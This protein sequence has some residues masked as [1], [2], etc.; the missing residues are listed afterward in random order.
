LDIVYDYYVQLAL[1]YNF[2]ALLAIQANR[3]GSKVNRGI[4]S[5]RLLMMEDV[6]EAWGPMTSA[7]NVITLNR[8]VNAKRKNRL[9]LYVAKSRSSETGQAIVAQSNFSHG[10]THSTKMKSTGYFGTSTMEGVIDNYL[11]QF[12][13]IFIPP[14]LVR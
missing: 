3:E 2:H 5:N 11:V 4:E 10:L 1:E 6:A 8:S 12:N 7:T 9:T 13:G 14:E